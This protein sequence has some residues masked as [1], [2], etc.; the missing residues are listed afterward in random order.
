MPGNRVIQYAQGRNSPTAH[1]VS[2]T[3]R[4]T[5]RLQVGV[6]KLL[7]E[8]REEISKIFHRQAEILPRKL[9]HECRHLGASSVDGEPI[10]PRICGVGRGGE[11][12]GL[13]VFKATEYSGNVSWEF[14][15]LKRF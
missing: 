9:H 14:R 11:E 1:F 4:D 2:K 13:R 3:L 10:W 12:R 15:N 6:K 7:L 8:A 5:E